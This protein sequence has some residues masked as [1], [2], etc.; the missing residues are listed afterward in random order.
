MTAQAGKIRHARQKIVLLRIVFIIYSLAVSSSNPSNRQAVQAMYAQHHSWL[1]QLLRRTVGNS[2]QARDLA[3]DTFE[4]VLRSGAAE[5]LAEPRSYLTTIAKR[6]AIDSHRRRVIEQAYLDD[7]ARTPEATAPSPEAL[8]LVAETLDAL[9]IMLDSM[10]AR[11]RR[12]FVLGQFE[13]RPY[14]DI[15]VMLNISVHTVQRDMT[16]AW[17]HCYAAIYN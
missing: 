1:V 13:G 2:E 15:A 6:L 10:S 11:E 17:K 12:V 8:A 9:C 7:L 16:K 4:R 3:H 5:T 14:A